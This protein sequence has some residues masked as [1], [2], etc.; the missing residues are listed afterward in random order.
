MR[1][2]FHLTA[3]TGWI[4]DPHGITVHG[5]KYHVFYQ[6]VPDTMVWAANC[7]WGHAIGDDL[8]ALTRLPV[9]IAPGDGDDGIWT[10]SLVTD[11]AGKTTVFYTSVQQPGIGIGRIRTATPTDDSWVSWVKGPVLIEAPTDLD[12]V[13]YRD[14]FVFRDGEGWRMFV[15]AGL[16]DGTAS[17]VGYSSADLATWNYDGIAAERSTSEREPVWMGALWECPQLFEI[18]G[19]HVL[20]SS[21]WDD[22]VLY[23]AGYGIGAYENGKFV[24]ETWG[25]LTFGPSYY[26][27]SFFRDAAGRPCL[28][29]WMRGIRDAEAAW[30]GA[31]SIPH[32][33]RLDGDRLVA[34]PHP[35]L[36]RYRG[37]PVAP[38]GPIDGLALDAL[39]SPDNP[40]ETLGFASGDANVL[41]VD[42]LGGI[43]TAT[44]GD[45]SWT[46]PYPGG[47]VRVLL[48]GPAAEISTAGGILGFAIDPL[49]T[50]YTVDAHGTEVEIRPLS[51]N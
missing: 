20:V 31:H 41:L 47:P 11:P 14:P 12:V 19:R 9:A 4:N 25:Q 21:V 44:V 29:L 43:L 18:D 42:V 16:A 33:L 51:R 48:D 34:E 1:P 36:D 5:G 3:E 10:G 49:G 13:A 6:Y 40:T 22:D 28:T 27:P 39:W 45:E 8:I 30:A 50:G 38:S 26:A 23:Y 46:M 35:D 37:E 24:A 7:H 32:T 17:A 2:Q 15:G